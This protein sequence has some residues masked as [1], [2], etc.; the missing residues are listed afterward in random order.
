MKK[1]IKWIIIIAIIGN[2]F[3]YAGGVNMKGKISK[4]FGNNLNRD[5]D[6]DGINDS[7]VI[8]NNIAKG[9]GN[10]YGYSITTDSAGRIY[11]TGSSWNGSN[12][13]MYVIRLNKEGNLDNS[14]GNNGKVILNNIAGK[15]R[16]DC[17][18]FITFDC[19]RSIT[20][21]KNTGEIYFTGE[22]SKGNN[23]DMYVVKIE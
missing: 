4:S 19:G 8:F 23:Y 16:F 12:Y 9:N 17:G 1:L 18:R 2:M 20:I 3:L 10:N 7:C 14:F 13:D 21:D 11:V 5:I 6:G 22:S 15:G